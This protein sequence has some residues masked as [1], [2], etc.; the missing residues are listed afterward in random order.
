MVWR[1]IRGLFTSGGTRQKGLQIGAPH[2]SFAPA[3]PVT[4][5]SALQISTVWA[6]VRLLA[7][8]VS[9]LPIKVYRTDGG[10]R[11]EDPDHPLARLFAGRLNR[12]GQNSLE[13]FET[14]TWQL[15]LLGNAYAIIQRN[16]RGDIIGLEPMMTQQMEVI[17]TDQGVVYQYTD[18]SNVKVYDQS[19]IWH[20]KLMGNGVIGMS[21][22]DYARNS[23]GIAAAIDRRVSKIYSNGAKPAGVLTI[24]RL[25]T[26]EQREKIKENFKDLKEGDEDRLFVLEADM[27]YQQISMSPQDIEM[28][29]SIKF[30]VED[31]CRFFGVPSILVNDNGASTAWGSGIQ[32][33]VT[34]FYRLGLRP[35]LERYESSAVQWLLPP[36]ERRTVEIE[37]DFNAL[38][39]SDRAERIRMQKEAVTG[40]L[41]TPNEARAE[42]GLPPIDGG[43]QLYM[44]Q[45]MVPISILKNGPIVRGLQRTTE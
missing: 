11:R 4:L 42:E 34:G 6:C 31:L 30:R 7:E 3:V 36:E 15:A 45:Q 5:D 41:M 17:L 2:H 25:L 20:V 13:F 9:A 38:T 24:D 12:L 33:I 14:M 10:V 22:L 35:Y 37:F 39:R 18:A 16:T 40:A 27:K 43:D 1:W 26:K 8:S 32:Q 28:L 29:S 19:R 23:V 21:P 44:Q